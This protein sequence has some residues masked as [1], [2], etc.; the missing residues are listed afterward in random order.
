MKQRAIFLDRDGV[1]NKDLKYL[2]KIEDFIFINGIFKVCQHLQNLDYKIFII[3][4]QSGI[5]RGY[6]TQ[7]DYQILTDWMI[8]EFKKSDINILD[9]FHCPHLPNANCNCRKPKPGMFFEAKK[10]YDIDMQESWLIGDKEYDVIAANSAGISSTILVRSGH[11]ID[12]KK[13]NAEY[14][15]DSINQVSKIINK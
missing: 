15:I 3:T 12:E 5:S 7:T 2:Y 14:I 11:I 8:A 1:I 9:V 6:Y 10:I 13:S 4:N